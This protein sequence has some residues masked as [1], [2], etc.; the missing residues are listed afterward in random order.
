[1]KVVIM[2]GGMGTRVMSLN[3]QVPKPMIE[4]C[5][6]PVLLYQIECLKKQGYTD[7]IVVIGH[8]GHMIEEFL[9]DGSKWGVNITYI[10]EE[11][12]LGTAGAL[13]YLKEDIEDDFLLLNGDIIFDVDIERFRNVHK[14]NSTLATIL[15][16]P[17]NHPYDSGIIVTGDDNRVIRWLTKEEKRGW[18]KNRVN[19]GMHMISPELLK[20]FA[21]PEEKD[22]DRDILK[23]LIVE[24]KLHVYDSPEYIKDMGTPE[25]YYEVVKDVEAGL[26]ARRN[27]RN[28]Q[29]AIFLDRDG[30]INKYVG[31]I[32]NIDD[33]VLVEGVSDAIKR[34][35]RSGYLCIV[36]TN[37]PVIA[38]GE[39]TIDELEEIHNKMETL[40][41]C[42]GVYVDDIFYC[43]HHP[44]RGF[45]GE[46][47]EYKIDCACR[48]PKP[49]MILQAAEKYN[50]D[51]ANSWMIGDSENDVLAGINAGCKV[52]L[53]GEGQVMGAVSYSDLLTCVNAGLWEEDKWLR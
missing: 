42:N 46:R 41:G 23:P 45:E 37:Q 33:F 5:G 4:I 13:Y 50:I 48:K 32:R 49:G 28:K 52:A 20:V 8:L 21:C 22:L 31:F 53:I 26:P 40:L 10:K 36:I 43:P 24:G 16:H 11:R 3:T 44:D 29:R 30:T 51:L 12:P 39:L 38:R 18:H 35:N 9:G 17:N 19:A 6:K 1:M 2:A 25:R 47:I 34:I 14:Q 7:I 27:L 15:T